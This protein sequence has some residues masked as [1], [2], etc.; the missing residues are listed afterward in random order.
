[1]LTVVETPTYLRSIAG[2]WTDDEAMAIVDFLVSQPDAGDVIPGTNG[3]RKLRWQ[4][5]GMG[6]R[7]GARVIYFQRLASGQIVLL[8]G[9]AKA[10]FDDLPR[11]YLAR[12]KELYDA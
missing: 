2:L 8:I 10:K 3:L 4:R 9:Y 11:E 12:L 7:G 6:R 1:M 5:A